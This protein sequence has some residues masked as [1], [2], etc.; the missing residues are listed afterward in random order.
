MRITPLATDRIYRLLNPLRVRHKVK[1][2]G[3]DGGTARQT[4]ALLTRVFDE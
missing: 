1:A 3:D 4:P 2:L